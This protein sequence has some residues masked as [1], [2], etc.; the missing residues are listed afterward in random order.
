MKIGVAFLFLITSVAALGQDLAG[1]YVLRGEMEMGS[2]L[3]LKPDGKFEFMLAYGAADYWGKGTWKREGNS[4]IFQSNGKRGEPFRQLR[5]EAGKAGQI[6]IWVLGKNGKGADNIDVFLL[7]IGDKPLE[8]R[9]DSD[10]MAAFPESP[11][12]SGVAFAVPVY[13]V[14]TKPYPIEAAHRDYYFEIDGDSI[15]QVFFDSELLSIDGANL[16]MT[17]WGAD[18]PL[19]YEREKQ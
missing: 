17:H 7:L 13:D 3:L 4:V 8:G 9:T 15:T 1:S 11:K 18:H 19:R 5:S 14:A 2:E 6:R 16:I 12:A 10:G